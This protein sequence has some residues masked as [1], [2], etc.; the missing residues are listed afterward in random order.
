[1]KIA[2]IKSHSL[3]SEL[4]TP[5][6]FSQGWVNRRSACVVEVDRGALERYRA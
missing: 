3:S 5:F 6:A 2:A 4:E 1:M